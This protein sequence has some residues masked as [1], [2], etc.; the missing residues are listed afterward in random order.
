MQKYHSVWKGQPRDAIGVSISPQSQMARALPA[1][2]FFRNYIQDL[3][4]MRDK[5]AGV[6]TT[7]M[8]NM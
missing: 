2:I 1:N 3:T 5:P 6:S 8:K 7:L 4:V